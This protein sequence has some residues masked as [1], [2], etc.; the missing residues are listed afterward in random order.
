[1]ET[2]EEMVVAVFN[3]TLAKAQAAKFRLLS[4]VSNATAQTGKHDVRGFLAA[5][6]P[7]GADGRAHAQTGGASGFKFRVFLRAKCRFTVQTVHVGD[8]TAVFSP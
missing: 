5:N 6:A 4:K 3:G 2:E 8:S 7:P 1:M